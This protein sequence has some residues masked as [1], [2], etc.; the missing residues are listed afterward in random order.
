MTYRK[1]ILCVSIVA[2]LGMSTMVYADDT[3]DA[4]TNAKAKPAAKAGTSDENLETIV[5]KGIRESLQRSLD[6]K[7]ESASHVEVITA[8]DV[9]KMPDKNVADSLARVPGVNASSASASEGGF[10]ENDRVSMR[11]TNPSLTQTLIN[12][13]GI[14]SGDWFVLNQT[15]TVGRSVSYSLLPSEIIG[16]VVV[17]K[18]SQASQVEGGVVGSVDIITRKPLDFGKP[19]TLEANIGMVYADLPSKNDPQFSGLAN[20]KND[21]GTFGVLVQAFSETRHLRRD[22]QEL[23]GYEQIQPGSAVATAHPDLANVYYPTLIGSALFEQKRERKGG[24]IEFDWRPNDMLGFDLNA[25]SS[26]LDASNYNRNYMEW[27]TNIVKQG[28]GQ[29]PDAG[30]VVRNGTLVKANFS[31]VAGTTYGIYDM[32]SRPKSS[33]QSN[34]VDLDVDFHPT[35]ALSFTGKFGTSKANGDTPVQDV[36]EFN[37]GI[38]TGAGFALNG[39]NNAASWNLGNANNSSPSADSLNWIFGSQNVKAEDKEKWAQLDGAYAFLD[40]SLNQ[41]QFGVRGSNHDR[42]ANGTIGQGPKCSNGDA[43]NWVADTFYCPI[44]STS[45]FNPA[46]FPGTL[47]YP[48]DFGDGLGGAF[49]R[50]PWYFDANGLGAYDGKFTNRD[51]ITRANW[52]QDYSLEE[53]NRA[54]YIQADFSGTGWAADIGVRYVTTKEHVVANVAT[55]ASTPGA[56]TTSAFGP[57]IPASF[58]NTYH[59]VLPSGNIKFDLNEQMLLRFAASKTMTRADYSA[60]AGT[61]N[62]IQPPDLDASGVIG[63][64]SGSN[65]NLKPVRS[66]NLDAS[67]EWYFAEHSLFSVSVFHMDLTSYIGYGRVQQSFVTFDQTHPNGKLIPYVLT[68]PVNTSGTV[69]GAEFSFEQPIF[70]HFG[71]FANYTFADGEEDGGKD[72]VGTSKHTYNVGGYFENDLFNARVAYTH[73]S[74][75]FSGLDRSTAFY[76]AGSGNLSASFG[77]KINENFLLSLDAL[78]LNDPKLKY[79]ALNKDQPRS[80]Y[81][82]GSQ[83]YLSLHV[84][85]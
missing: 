78:N 13:H 25:F 26:K 57:Y 16:Q 48:G 38:G 75:F 68:V 55:S 3:A 47:H 21:D 40:G 31:P 39:I 11:G 15:G 2:A 61:I 23:L 84:K 66:T 17:H 49:P 24:L 36:A 59:D 51:P 79:Y 7:R 82:N 52:T 30:Y 43:F 83:Y 37:T 34:F 1:S 71:V 81:Q 32:I 46:N 20:F 35:D 6:V 73:R 85:F 33:S 28:A 45:P 29:G 69:K 76:Q 72:L 70:E 67:F 74:D 65:P 41:L 53:K 50:N 56:I 5:V 22:G 9:G 27:V 44:A 42:S 14:A 19:M 80:V 18:S 10:D 54:A 58:D 62:L 8:Q 60:L 64:G 77:Y 4:N 63:A 12:G